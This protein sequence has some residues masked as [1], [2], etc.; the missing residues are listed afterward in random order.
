MPKIS[1]K[2]DLEVPGT[3]WLRHGMLYNCI[4]PWFIWN[5]NGGV[6][7]S[8]YSVESMVRRMGTVDLTMVLPEEWL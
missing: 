5:V 7:E 2:K 8:A 6:L 1:R 4:Y 3:M